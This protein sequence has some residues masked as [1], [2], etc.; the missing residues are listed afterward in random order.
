MGKDGSPPLTRRVPGAA[1]EGPAPSPRRSGVRRQL[2]D[3]L[4]AKMQAAVDAAHAAD[5]TP[6]RASDPDEPITEPLP[7][8]QAVL[9]AQD[10]SG[11]HD[12]EQ[13]LA[14][15]AA[16]V[17]AGAEPEPVGAAPANEVPA[18]QVPDN[19]APDSGA[20]ESGVLAGQAYGGWLA[21]SKSADHRVAAGTGLAGTGTGL[22]GTGAA[23]TGAA[24][25]G[26]AGT[27]AAGTGAADSGLAQGPAA[28]ADLTVEF[29]RVHGPAADLSGAV[30]PEGPGT[31][32][33]SPAATASGRLAPPAIPSAAIP[34]ADRVRPEPVRPDPARSEPTRRKPVRPEPARRTPARFESAPARPRPADPAPQQDGWAGLS[35]GSASGARS[36]TGREP[37]DL[38]PGLHPAKPRVPQREGHRSARRLTRP[39]L[40]GIAA[41]AVVLVGAGSLAFALF[42]RNSLV[43]SSDNR[44]TD[45][46]LV[47]QA[48]DRGAAAS[49]IVRQVSQQTVVSCD[50]LMCTALEQR[51]FPTV[52]LRLIKPTAH[53]PPH[54]DLI[55]VTPPV[56][57]QFGARLERDLAPAA[58][59][60]FGPASDR[61]TV[62]VI[63]S[64]GAAAYRAAL[65]ADQV[66]R[67][68]VGAGLVTSRQIAATPAASKA[69]SAGEVD[70]RALI[71]IT[72][73]AAQHPIDILAIGTSYPGATPGLPLRV[74]EF[75]EVDPA[76]KLGQRAYVKSMT[77]LLA[78]QPAKYRPLSVTTVT[79]NGHAALRVEFA[80]PSPLG[81]LSPAQ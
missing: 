60:D 14:K 11:E 79:V 3:A 37:S 47:Q 56:S 48:K 21:E 25:T 13:R 50:Q 2:P 20:P 45:G 7:A 5:P 58:L 71:V 6:V 35:V 49:W 19:G 76:A 8:L 41:V 24:G 54:A 42:A 66:I 63:A 26:A 57:E 80:A 29:D 23:G 30:E 34:S 12:Q 10:W 72:A 22:A 16:D 43:P 75:A 67:K 31:R 51:G 77:D 61:I 38:V 9:A 28:D 73:L 18:D 52:Q 46:A 62:R 55:V 78:A 40:I 4:I 74:V 44:T 15:P 59:A 68:T 53:T 17:Q 33:D 69:M 27:G 65:S 39:V 81:L 64:H 32:L 1:R 36:G 70:A